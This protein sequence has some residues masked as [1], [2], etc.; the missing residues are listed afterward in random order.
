MQIEAV[1]GYPDKV[2]KRLHI[3]G[4]A[5]GGRIVWVPGRNLRL[6]IA[7]ELRFEPLPLS[8]YDAIGDA[9]ARILRSSSL[10]GMG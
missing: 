6:R 3:G 4:G 1:V 5:D 8:T 7:A 10:G 9:A 2:D